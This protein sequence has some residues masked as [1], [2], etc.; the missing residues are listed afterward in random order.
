MPFIQTQRASEMGCSTLILEPAVSLHHLKGWAVPFQ[1]KGQTLG[2]ATQSSS[3]LHW[4]S[5]SR[6]LDKMT[7]RGHFL[8]QPFCG[9]DPV[10][11]SPSYT[12]VPTISVK[13][14]RPCHRC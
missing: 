14:H 7:S 5:L 4:D 9:T 8:P 12:S 13:A 11:V 10:I 3:L 1:G 6:G 2:S